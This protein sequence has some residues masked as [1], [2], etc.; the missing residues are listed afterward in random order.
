MKFARRH[1]CGL[2]SAIGLGWV[3]STA[4]AHAQGTY[5][6][7]PLRIIVPWPAGGSVDIATRVVAEQLST[8]LG[9]PVLVE[10]KPGA[11]G[12]IGAAAAAKAAPDGYTLLIATTPMII[13]RSLSREPL[14]DLAR[15]FKPISLLVTT[16]YVMVVNPAV[17]GSVQELVAK[18]KANPGKMAYASS[19]P[20]T[21]LHL[22]AETFKR[23][24]GI[25]VVHAPYKGA[26]PALADLVGG[27][28]QMMFP[29]V[30]VAEPLIKSGQLKAIAMA[31][32][33]R[34][35]SMP[36]VPTMEEAGIKG[37]D[38]VEW[39][40]LVVPAGTPDN[41][42]ALLSRAVVKVMASTQVQQ[43]LLSRGFQPA[44]RGMDDYAALIR[45]EVKKWPAI[46]RQAGLHPE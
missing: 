4:A 28:V 29:G 11:T 9:Q 18:A 46:V 27:H 2:A 6:D 15:D 37:I 1:V 23:Q 43:R 5:P 14:A 35:P 40:G 41:I 32:K 45:E 17:A 19:G 20:G 44:G 24:A 16:N 13:N 26:P 12:N 31:S 30:P 42:T 3:L 38:F 22:I 33:Q 7:R 39:Y 34:L 21:Q 36:D 25:D 10:N 8:D